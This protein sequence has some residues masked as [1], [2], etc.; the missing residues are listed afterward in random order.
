MDQM[1]IMKT[2]QKN[3][4]TGSA[5]ETL[6]QIDFVLDTLNV[7]AYANW[8]EGEVVDGP[9]IESYWTT[10]T[11]MYPYKLMPDPSGA[12]RII[13]WGGRVFYGKDT[14]VTAGKLVDPDDSDQP[15]GADG[16]RPGQPRAKKIERPV[17]LV[18]LELPRDA[19]DSMVSSK[20][21]IEDS[22]IDNEAVE[23]AYDEGLGDNDA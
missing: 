23:A 17:W 19:I 21:A 2:L 7:Y 22:D 6:M 14:L 9:H 13:N 12:E 3:Y 8:L 1:D 16:P 10:V 5:I 15:D 4:E 18:T 11:L 20:Q